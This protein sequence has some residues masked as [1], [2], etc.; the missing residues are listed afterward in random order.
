MKSYEDLKTELIEIA[1]ILEK[2]PDEVKKQVFEL[3]VSKF[4]GEP[5]GFNSVENEEPAP[6]QEK[7]P[8]PKKKTASKPKAAPKAA[9]RKAGTE[10][11]KI[12]RN[13]D[14]RAGAD[15]P[16]FSD[17][18]NEKS[19]GST[20]EFNAVAVYYLIKMKGHKE[21]T[22]NQAYTCYSEVKKKPAEHFK[23]SFRDTQNKQ[24]YIEFTDE[25]NIV[26]PHRGV[27]FVEHDLPKP[28]KEKK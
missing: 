11:Y 1:A 21:V 28:K 14:L 25:G 26:I 6:P 13:L 2:Y 5:I 23:Q 17:F 3:L 18:Y 20:A 27:V 12:D 7:S 4:L 9:K 10:S 16:S 22:L 24:G 8:P 15:S 19:P